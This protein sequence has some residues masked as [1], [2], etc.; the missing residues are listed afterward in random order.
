[1]N[2]K[3]FLLAFLFGII[4]ISIVLF[5]EQITGYADILNMNFKS[6]LICYSFS[7]PITAI[8]LI[9]ET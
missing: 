4:S 9:F 5:L 7:I 2:W 1:M 6:W 8:I 3:D